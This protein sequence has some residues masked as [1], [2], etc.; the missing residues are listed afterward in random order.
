M[1]DLDNIL[2][3]LGLKK[4]CLSCRLYEEKNGNRKNYICFHCGR[5]YNEMGIYDIE[6]TKKYVYQEFANEKIVLSGKDVDLI[7]NHCAKKGSMLPFATT[8]SII[9]QG[10]I[11]KRR[12]R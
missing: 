2:N 8:L 4:D 3:Q 9:L 6:L 5:V 11:E 7:V 12:I 1:N 10:A